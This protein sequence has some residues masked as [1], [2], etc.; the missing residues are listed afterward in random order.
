MCPSRGHVADADDEKG[1]RA[2]PWYKNAII[3]EL[4]VRS[5]FDSNGDGIGDFPGL[6]EKLDY[7]QDLGV[8]AVWL[9]PYYPSPLKD[10]GYDIADFKRVHPDYGTLGDF[11]T[12]VRE[13]HQRGLKVI[14][15]LVLNHTSDEH[16]WFRRAEH[17]KLGTGYRTFNAWSDTPERYRDAGLPQPSPRHCRRSRSERPGKKSCLARRETSWS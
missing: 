6:T 4:H 11:K 12:F 15:E 9:L 8:T 7:L 16:P 3:Y 14:T 13:A 1:R 17:P 5:F 10:G 2:C